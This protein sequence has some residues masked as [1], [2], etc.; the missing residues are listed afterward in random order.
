MKRMMFEFLDTFYPQ[1]R[2]LKTKF[3]IIP[4]YGI[5][6][7]W[8]VFQIKLKHIK[9]LCDYFSCDT[10]YCKGIYEEWLD[11]RPVHVRVKNST[12]DD[13]MVLLTEPQNS[14]TFPY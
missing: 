8:D 4:M 1:V 3:G 9:M 6:G 13:L 11:N 2:L 12:N 5:K 7:G 14:A 10:D